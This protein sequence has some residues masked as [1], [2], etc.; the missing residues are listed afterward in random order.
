MFCLHKD[1]N[2]RIHPSN[3][4]FLLSRLT[5]ASIHRSKINGSCL[6]DPVIARW[7]MPYAV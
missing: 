5:H 2:P 1:Y 4:P 6:V 3:H 7:K